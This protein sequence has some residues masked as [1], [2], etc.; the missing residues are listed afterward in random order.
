MAIDLKAAIKDAIE[1]VLRAECYQ[2]V[3]AGEDDEFLAQFKQ[4]GGSVTIK[5]VTSGWFDCMRLPP[6]RDETMNDQ[7]EAITAY[8]VTD[9][10]DIL[11]QRPADNQ[12]GFELCDDDQAW[13]GGYGIVNREFT[14]LAD[15]DPRI[16][17]ADRE[18]LGH[19]LDKD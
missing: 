10:G 2:A 3:N 17:P 4:L 9:K 19:L 6:V 18:Q 16:T 8:V 15:D 14:V 12:W 1:D 7:T 11:V 13:V 5:L